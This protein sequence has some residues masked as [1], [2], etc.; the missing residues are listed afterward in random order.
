LKYSKAGYLRPTW[1]KEQ[2]VKE[3]VGK[4]FRQAAEKEGRRA[5][6]I[7]VLGR[8]CV[9]VCLKFC[10]VSGKKSIKLEIKSMDENTVS[11]VRICL[12]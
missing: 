7:K 9:S 3:E 12:V 5:Q 1:L 10:H 6:K 11:S 2:P 8:I 4:G